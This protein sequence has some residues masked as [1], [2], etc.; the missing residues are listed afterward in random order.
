MLGRA[1]VN[2]VELVFDVSGAGERLV[3]CHGLASCREGDRDVIEAFASS[4]FQVLSYDARGHGSSS[5]VRETAR[6]TYA[7]LAEDLRAL[8]E[9]VG[10][11]AAVLAG[12][13]MGAA[14]AA[15]TAALWPDRARALVMARPGAADDAG[16]R[17]PAWLQLLFAGGAHAI[18]AG[19]IEAAIE[20]LYSIPMA[21]EALESD[22]SRL[23]GL[24]ADWGR[25][26]PLSIAAALEG[27][28]QTSPLD[29]GVLIEQ[30]TSPSMVIPG[31]DLIHPREAGERVAASITGAVLVP[32]FEGLARADEVAN[33][34][35]L[36]REFVDGLP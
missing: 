33:L 13:S 15:R 2:D 16:E 22:P 29:H 34:I 23:D 28:P 8:L 7:A 21:R 5:P 31:S 30:I 27:V 11:D 9:H 35:K 19:G 25:H 4:G 1:P 3:W 10:W 18:R 14:T 12:A 32:P 6:M 20:Y 17:A 24:R 26:D 36:V